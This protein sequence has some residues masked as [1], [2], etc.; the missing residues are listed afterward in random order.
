MS[1]GAVAVRIDPM[2]TAGKY[3]LYSDRFRAET[4]FDS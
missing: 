4:Y 1:R 3:D 2:A